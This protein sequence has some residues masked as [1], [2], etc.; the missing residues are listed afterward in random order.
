MGGGARAAARPRMTAREPVAPA[1]VLREARAEDLDAIVAIER[2]AFSDP[3]SRESFASV[4]GEPPVHFGVA[5]VDDVVIGYVVAW[6][7]AGD[8]EIGNIAVE[9]EHRARGVG[10][11]LLDG[12][13][14]AARARR[15]EAV[16]L[17]V[18]ESNIAAQRMYERR[19][20]T[21]V[22]RRRRYYRRPEEDAFILRLELAAPGAPRR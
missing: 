7:L 17:E 16:Y 5:T 12:A 15:V 21:R 2:R 22:G 13:L 10:S 4:L 8:G 14:E 3:W 20:F 1:V 19:G 6:F 18:R 9:D 11:R